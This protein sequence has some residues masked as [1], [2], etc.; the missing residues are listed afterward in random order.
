VLQDINNL[1]Q[2]TNLLVFF[3]ADED[4]ELLEIIIDEVC[5]HLKRFSVD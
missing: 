1:V 2:F 3:Q 5:K 4:P